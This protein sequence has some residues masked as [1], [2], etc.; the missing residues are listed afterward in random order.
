MR[1]HTLLLLLVAL[2]AGCGSATAAC[3]RTGVLPFTIHAR[4]SVTGE[5]LDAIATLTV[6]SLQAPIDTVTGPL[7]SDPPSLP[8]V[9]FEDQTGRFHIHFAVPGYRPF[10]QIALVEAGPAPCRSPKIVD[11]LATLQPQ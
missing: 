11:I 5:S 8:L 4:S 6:Y 10:D 2:E 1:Y 9:H 3:V 7:S